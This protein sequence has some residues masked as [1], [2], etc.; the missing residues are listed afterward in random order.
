[1]KRFFQPA[2]SAVVLTAAMLQ[3]FV[4]ASAV[5]ITHTGS[6]THEYPPNDGSGDSVSAQDTTKVNLL[7]GGSIGVD[8]F[9]YDNSTVNVSGGTI[10]AYLTAH[11][12][13]TL[14]IIADFN[15]APGDYLDGSLLDWGILTGELLDGTPINNTVKILNSATVTL[16]AIPEPSSFAVFGIGAC[17][18]VLARKTSYWQ[19]KIARLRH[20]QNRKAHHGRPSG[21]PFFIGSILANP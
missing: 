19:A 6:G 15:F 13:R 5:V 1:M 12:D 3:A 14:T 7:T 20:R 10:V 4:P 8:L 21:H 9:A 17:G 16:Q 11:D 2:I 18:L